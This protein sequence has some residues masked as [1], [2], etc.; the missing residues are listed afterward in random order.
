MENKTNQVTQIS[1]VSYS[2]NVKA[3][4]DNKQPTTLEI[5]AWLISYLTELLDTEPTDID[6]TISFNRFGLDSSA[7]IAM[8]GDLEKCLGCELEPTIIYDYPTIESLAQYLSE[9]N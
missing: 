9:K 1:E 6:V 3:N 8:T 5:Q 4:I 2:Q 7:A